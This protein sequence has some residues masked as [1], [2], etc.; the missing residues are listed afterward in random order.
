VF[1]E[2]IG[3]NI[4]FVPLSERRRE[5]EEIPWVE[6]A[7]V[8]RVLPDQLRVSL[9]ERKPVAFVRQGNTIGL[10][11]ANGVLLSMPAAAMAQHHYSF[12]V[13]T[14][15][16]PADPIASRK[17]RIA[18]YLRML[19]ELD[20]NNQRFSE[21]ISEIDLTDPED[22]RVLMPEQGDDILAH[23][24]E[25]KFAER[26][27]R[28]KENIAQLRKQFPQLKSVDLRYD[29]DMVLQMKNAATVEEKSS[30]EEGSG[31]KAAAEG[32]KTAAAEP[33]SLK[34]TA[35]K[36]PAAKTTAAKTDNIGKPGATSA[37]KQKTMT[38]KQKAE[39]EEAAREKVLE[40]KAAQMR[41]AR[42]KAAAAKQ[43]KKPATQEEAADQNK[44]SS[45]AQPAAVDINGQKTATSRH[46]VQEG[47]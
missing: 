22:A 38:A 47:Q 5:L 7:T 33:A 21:Q 43:S 18:V 30:V 40:A 11:D 25:D 1:G 44:R 39:K 12:P 16:D 41:A 4:F 45:A 46:S 15:I 27:R 8:M 20:A 28:Y 13:V 32:N 35:A 26:Y 42:E 3:R 31:G 29:Q 34:S 37:A 19:A 17:A 36:T 10:V 6:H 14:G 2:D 23:F 24:G 9:V